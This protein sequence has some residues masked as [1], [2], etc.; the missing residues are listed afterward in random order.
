VLCSSFSFCHG[1][2]TSLIKWGVMCDEPCG[3]FRYWPGPAARP[4]PAEPPMSVN[5]G[6]SGLCTKGGRE[7]LE[8]LGS[9]GQGLT[10]HAKPVPVFQ[11]LEVTLVSYKSPEI[12]VT[13]SITGRG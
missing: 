1:L 5:L 3:G 7:E 2:E 10:Q 9:G 13:R 6:S 4:R 8:R 12:T 11:S